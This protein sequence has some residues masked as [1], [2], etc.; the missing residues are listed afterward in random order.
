MSVTTEK[1]TKAWIT[2]HGLTFCE[3]H[4]PQESPHLRAGIEANPT[5]TYHDTPSEMWFLIDGLACNC[6]TC[7]PI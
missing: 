2:Q 6:E 5:A 3:D 4:A 7:D 1:S